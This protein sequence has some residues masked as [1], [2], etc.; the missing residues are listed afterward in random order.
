EP[1]DDAPAQSKNP[2]GDSADSAALTRTDGCPVSMVTGEELLTLDDGTLDGR[3]PFVFTRLYRSSAA[4]LD[5]GLG[6]GWSHALAHRLLLEGE[7]V[8]WIDQENRRTTFP[9]P[10]AQRSAIH[11]SLARAVIYL[12]SEPD[13]LIVAQPGEQA[14]FLHFRDGYL[15]ALSDRYDN[16]LTI[17]RNIHGDISR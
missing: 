4:D 13:E 6:R 2:N 5:V 11:N 7:Q 14:P 8:I 16:R 12:G 10:N 1:H 3:L 9:L 17:Q 15:T